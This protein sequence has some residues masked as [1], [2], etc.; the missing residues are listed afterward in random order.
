M[1]SVY[2]APQT[3]D[4]E[5]IMIENRSKLSPHGKSSSSARLC[6]AEKQMVYALT[7]VTC[8]LFRRGGSTNNRMDCN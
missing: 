2:T 8:D 1:R 7:C 5:E 4:L 3:P 6:R